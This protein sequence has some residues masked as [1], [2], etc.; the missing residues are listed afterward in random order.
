MRR[1]ASP[2]TGRPY[3]VQRVCA[4]FDHPRSSYYARRARNGDSPVTAPAASPAVETAA[5]SPTAPAIGAP[6]PA[7]PVLP[8][9]S[10]LVPPPAPAVPKRG[11]KP[12]LTDEALLVL[13]RADLA[14]SPFV[15]EGHRKVWA[16]LRHV[17]HLH[18]AKKR[19]LRVMREHALLSPSRVPQGDPKLHDGHIV[20]DAPN[21]LW[22]I[23][24]ARV[25]T[26]HDGWCWL[27]LCVEHFNAECTGWHVSKRGTRYEAL[28]PVYMG[29]KQH[30]AGVDKNAARG[31]ALRMDHGCQ[32]TADHFQNEIKFLGIAP[33]FAF[34]AEPQTNGVA[35]RF[36][37][38]LKE[39]CIY[40]R[41]FNTVDEVRE[42]VRAFVTLY[43][44]SWR[45]EKNGF[46]TPSEARQTYLT[47]LAA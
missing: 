11:P 14:A 44:E 8:I 38:T 43:N 42:A 34:V 27:F 23:D 18:V 5:T 7:A 4:A 15:G 16:R 39:Q 33:S 24:G 32:F 10:L 29:V 37:R 47:R 28:Q 46:L 40:G 31:L 13:I 22:G 21:L 26:V 9:S 17:Q 25:L 45:V 20:T 41:T 1:R 6:P 36:V 12:P 35:E 19:V 3:G 30:Y 2:A